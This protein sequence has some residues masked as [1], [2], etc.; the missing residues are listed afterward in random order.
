MNSLP[1]IQGTPQSTNSAI[2]SGNKSADWLFTVVA[3]CCVIGLL[4]TLSLIFR[5]FQPPS[6]EQIALFLG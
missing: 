2:G 5:H 6:T 4:V 3:M 1:T